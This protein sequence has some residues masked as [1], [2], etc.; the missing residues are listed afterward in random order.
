MNSSMDACYA[1]KLYKLRNSFVG[2]EIDK[3]NIT[4]IMKKPM[5]LKI[6]V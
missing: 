3:L 6:C 5:A 1:F 2:I 4:L